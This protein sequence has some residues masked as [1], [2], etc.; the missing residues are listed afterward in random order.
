MT[1]EMVAKIRTNF[2]P[3]LTGPGSCAGK[4]IALTEIFLV[5]ARTML[6]FDLRKTPGSTLGEGSPELGWGERN[7]KQFQIEDAFVSVK[8]GPKVQFKRRLGT[9][10][11]I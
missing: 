5:L 6:R 9:K 8:E 2:H 10:S 7:R 1:K 3:F 4:N 11:S